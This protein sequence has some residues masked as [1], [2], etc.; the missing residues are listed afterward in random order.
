MSSLRPVAEFVAYADAAGVLHGV[1]VD[2]SGVAVA[3]CGAAV[4]GPVLGVGAVLGPLFPSV[5]SWPLLGPT[6]FPVCEACS[7]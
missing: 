3:V 4:V 6:E 7:S 2:G 5:V 1:P